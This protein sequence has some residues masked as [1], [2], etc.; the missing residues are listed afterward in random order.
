MTD[1]L[2]LQAQLVYILLFLVLFPLGVAQLF[3]AHKIREQLLRVRHYLERVY[4]HNPILLKVFGPPLKKIT[5]RGYTVGRRIGG[6]ILI[7]ISIWCLIRAFLPPDPCE[8][9]YWSIT[10]RTD[11]C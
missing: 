1:Q 8:S 5:L 10:R 4:E 2:S 6:A 3:F 9:D 11:P 7:I